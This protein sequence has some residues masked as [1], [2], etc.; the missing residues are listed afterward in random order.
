MGYDGGWAGGLCLLYL[1]FM[2]VHV[3]NPINTTRKLPEPFT[4]N[5]VLFYQDYF[6]TSFLKDFYEIAPYKMGENSKKKATHMNKVFFKF[7]KHGFE[8]QGFTV[9]IKTAGAIDKWTLKIAY[10]KEKFLEMTGE[11][12]RMNY[13]NRK[14]KKLF[15]YE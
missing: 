3:A 8:A 4:S 5:D 7:L 10:G 14:L 1:F 13:K 6:E 11:Q 2:L 12:I 9:D 15:N